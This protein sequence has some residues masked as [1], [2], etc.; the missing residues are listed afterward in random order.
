[1]TLKE[2]NAILEV[3]KGTGTYNTPVLSLA[4]V[5]ERKSMQAQ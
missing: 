3:Q 5:T 1:M 4:L 2:L